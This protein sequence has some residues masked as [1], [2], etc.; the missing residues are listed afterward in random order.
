MYQGCAVFSDAL[1]LPALPHEFHA[2]D[3]DNVTDLVTL[4]RGRAFY[5]SRTVR[6]C[7][8]R[9]RAECRSACGFRAAEQVVFRQL[10]RVE[11]LT[12]HT[13]GKRRPC[14]G[15]DARQRERKRKVLIYHKM[16]DC[17]LLSS[18]SPSLRH[19]RSASEGTAHIGDFDMQVKLRSRHRTVT[20]LI[21]RAEIAVFL[22]AN[23]HRKNIE[24]LLLCH[25]V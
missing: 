17:C 23:S 18:I 13:F 6:L 12:Q 8:C 4:D 20:H 3:I 9:L 15:N 7:T 1:Q 21:L 10:D 19:A 24:H 16:E 22:P 25:L 14:V 2:V 5:H 11:I